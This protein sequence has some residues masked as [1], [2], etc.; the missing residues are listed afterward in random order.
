MSAVLMRRMKN[1]KKLSFLRRPVSGINGLIL[2]GFLGGGRGA[3]VEEG[4]GGGG[5]G[6]EGRGRSNK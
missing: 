4:G 6:S 1:L 5:G 3:A 2:G